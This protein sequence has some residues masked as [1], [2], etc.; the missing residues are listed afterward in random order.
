[1][2]PE[3]RDYFRCDDCGHVYTIPK[4]VADGTAKAVAVLRQQ[5]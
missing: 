3:S 4:A 2:I 5:M 1:M